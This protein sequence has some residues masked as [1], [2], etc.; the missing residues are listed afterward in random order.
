[1][2]APDAPR[3]PEPVAWVIPGDDTAKMDGS[4]DARID[5]E[6]EFSRPLWGVPGGLDAARERLEREWIEQQ[7]LLL[8]F[9]EGDCVAPERVDT[10]D[11]DDCW[12]KET[13][14][15]SAQLSLAA[16]FRGEG[17]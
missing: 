8:G 13:A 17:G 1:M 5:Q 7:R 2:T 9:D 4:I 10:C 11:P 15:R 6:G 12:C 16:V 14:A 3:A